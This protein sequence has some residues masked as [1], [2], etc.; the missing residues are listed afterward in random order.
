MFFSRHLGLAL[1]ICVAM[2]ATAQGRDPAKTHPGTLSM[3]PDAQLGLVVPSPAQRRAAFAAADTIMT[4]LRRDD[5][6]AKPV[7][8]SVTV[9]RVAGVTQGGSGDAPIEGS[10]HYGIVGALHYFAS[11]DNGRGGRTVSEDGGSVPFSVVVNAPGQLTDA[12]QLPL[13]LDHGPSVLS[14]FRETG[15]FRGHSVYNGE[16]AVVTG[17]PIPAFT[18]LTKERYYRLLILAAR[19][20]S[21][22]HA[23]QQQEGATT[24]AA[25]DAKTNSSAERAKREADNR[26]T[27]EAIKQFDPKAAEQFLDASRKA[28]ADLRA[29]TQDSSARAGGSLVGNL[30]R[31]SR[32]DDGKRIQD[33]ESMLR[34]LSPADRTAPVAVH[35]ASWDGHS[36]AL[37]GIDDPD[38]TPLVQLN[39]AFFDRSRPATAPQIITVCIPGLQGLEN[40]AYD[41]LAGSEREHERAMLERRTRDAVLIR[42]RLDWPAIEAL[43]KP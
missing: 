8:Y 13:M 6:I 40:T 15:Q 30:I 32:V 4:V 20:D 16:C 31:Q 29:Q 34:G 9:G 27:Y 23:Q 37:A 21:A 41:R 33:L 19:A 10:L 24:Q 25:S 26:K 22:R 18:P 1:C 28:E 5:A 7:G 3:Q 36:D 14:D 42:D 35:G 38:S 12:E 43:V 39:P 11:A 17:R 2:R